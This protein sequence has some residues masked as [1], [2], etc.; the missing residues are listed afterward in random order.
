M[1]RSMAAL[2]PALL[3]ILTAPAPA[4]GEPQPIPSALAAQ[5]TAPPAGPHTT[6]LKITSREVI[7]DVSVSDSDGR[8]VRDLTQ[9]DFTV[10]ENGKP[11]HIQNFA[12]YDEQPDPPDELLPLP[13]NVYT[14]VQPL[15]ETGPVN[16]FLLDILNAQP[17]D[18]VHAQQAMLRYFDRMPPGTQIAIFLLSTSGLHTLQ[19]FTSDPSLLRRAAQLPEYEFGAGMEKWTRDWYTTDAIDQ[20]AAYVARIRGRKNLLW[21]TPRMPILLVHDGGYSWSDPDPRGGWTPPDMGVVN[22]LMDTFE[23]LTAEQIAVYPVDP[24]GVQGVGME[25]LRAEAVAEG[26]GGIAFYNRNDL[27][28]VIQ[29]AI[30]NG[31]HFYTLS[32]HPAKTR[33]D[34]HFHAI[35]VVVDR[36]G[37]HLVYRRGYNAEDPRLHLPTAGVPLMNAALEARVFNATQLLFTVAVQP[38]PAPDRP[39]G[40]PALGAL[41]RHYRKKPLTRFNLVYTVEPSQL[42]FARGP[43]GIESSQLEFYA[44]AYNSNRKFVTS[45]KQAASLRYPRPEDPPAFQFAQQLDL[46]PGRLYLRIGVLDR[47]S[48]KVGTVE[49]PVTVP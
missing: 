46:P 43:D 28:S 19:P 2:V 16:V 6:T 5:T 34:G 14:N 47:L 8:P 17:A 7:V 40:S 3:A 44:A 33:D 20:I 21:F 27:D 23:L 10:F 1:P 29:T 49:V 48:N 35:K 41:A 45:L 4:R 26:L 18:L 39:A 32:Y 30:D 15:P 38:A 25:N 36:P 11:Q 42:A 13:P 37:L 24:G 22:R 9:S 31:S 12:F